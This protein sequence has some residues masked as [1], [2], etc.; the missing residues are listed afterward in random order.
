MKFKQEGG[1]ASSTSY[2]LSSLHLTTLEIAVHSNIE[3]VIETLSLTKIIRSGGRA[4]IRVRVWEVALI[5]IFDECAS[6]V[7]ETFSASLVAARNDSVVSIVRNA[8]VVEGKSTHNI[9]L[10]D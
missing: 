6:A 10:S 1:E 9:S 3:I 4:V 8:D 7:L 2:L 5:E